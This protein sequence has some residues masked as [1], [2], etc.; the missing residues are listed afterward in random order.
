MS[1]TKP[2]GISHYELLY[3][4]SNQ[5]SE[6]ELAPIVK[7]V[8]DAIKKQ[9]GVITLKEEWGKKRLA[10]QIKKFNHGYYNLVEFDLEGKNL[11]DV[12]RDLRMMSEVLRHQIIVKKVKTPEEI[13]KQKELAK[14][15]AAKEIKE[16]EVKEEKAQKEKSEKGK[17]DIGD[18]DEKLDKILETNDLL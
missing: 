7:K 8:D 18:L 3:I 6:D 1:K 14:K 9:D 16:E 12:D 10:Y 15:I 5:F 13:A 11:A 2:S 17:M 4:I